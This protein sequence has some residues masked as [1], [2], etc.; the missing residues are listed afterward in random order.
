VRQEQ[1]GDLYDLIME[2]GA[3]MGIA[4]GGYRAIESLRL[5]KGYRAW[6]GE[7]GPDHTPLEAG[8]AWAAKLKTEIPFLGREALLK[9][10]AEGLKKRLACFTVD[11][12]ET[13]LWGRESIF[14]NGELVGWLNSGGWGYTVGKSIGYGYV[15]WAEGLDRAFLLKGEYEL[16]VATR[17]V[18]ATLHLAPLYDPK[19][20]Q[21]RC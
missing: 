18:P 3:P 2:A 20:L 21:F 6:P 16:E 14:R 9:Q 10:R 4:D 17:R 8:L 11:D 7:V 1:A 13:V 5:E 15:R 12:P 19:G